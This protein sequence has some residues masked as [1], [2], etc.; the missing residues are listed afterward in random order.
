MTNL[1]K[2]WTPRKLRK[3]KIKP[4]TSPESFTWKCPRCV[5]VNEMFKTDIGDNKSYSCWSC[6]YTFTIGNIPDDIRYYIEDIHG[7]G[8]YKYQPRIKIR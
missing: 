2:I 4:G 1:S 5:N 7:E 8:D 6:L 3:V